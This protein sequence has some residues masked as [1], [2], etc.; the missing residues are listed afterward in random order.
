MTPEH[1]L[2]VED[3]TQFAFN[4]SETLERSEQG[5][6]VSVVHSG[7]KALQE[8]RETR[9]DLVLMDVQLAGE[10]NGVQ[11][12]AKIKAQFDI[13][14]VYLTAYAD[15]ILLQWAKATEPYGYLVKPVPDRELYATV[16]MALYKHSLDKKLKK[17]EERFRALAQNSLDIIT[18]IET[19]GT[20]SY[21]SP[22]LERVLGYSPDEYVGTSFY[23]RIHPED[24]PRV[25]DIFAELL[26]SSG[27]TPTVEFRYLHKD[28]SWR[29]IESSGGNLLDSPAVAGVV[30]SSRDITERKQMEAALEHRSVLLQTAADISHA[31][32]SILNLDELVRQ[33]VELIRERFGLYYVGLFLVEVGSAWVILQAGAGEVGQQI[34]EQGHKL[35]VGGDSMVGWCVANR[36]ACVAQNGIAASSVESGEEI[37]RLDNSSLSETRFELALPL[38][39]RGEAIGA[40]TIQSTRETTFGDEDIEV[41]QAMAN[42]LANAITNARLYQETQDLAAELERR[43]NRRTAQLSKVNLEL[44]A[45][46]AWRRQAEKKLRRHNRN[47]EL[48][49]RVDQ[50]LGSTLDLDRV[51]VTVLEEVHRLLGV[52]SCFIWLRDPE[53]DELVCRQA[54]GPSS[55]LVCGW[56]LPPGE[57]FVGWVVRTGKSLVVPDARIDKRDFKGIDER[58]GLTMCSF[59]TVPLRIQ[60]SVIG[61]L[62][63]ADTSIGC[64][65]KTDLELMEPLAASAA[66]AIENARLYK[67]A[68]GLRVFNENIVR[69]MEEGVLLEDKTGHITFANPKAVEMLGYAPEELVGQ[70]W[71][72][73]VPPEYLAQV[74]EESANRPQGITSRY[75]AALLNREGQQVPVI[76]SARPLFEGERFAGVLVVST[77]ITE[78]KQAEQALR[79]SEKRYHSLFDGMPVGLYRTTPAGQIL[80]AN[81]ALMQMLGIQEQSMLAEINMSDFYVH[82]EEHRQF[83][84]L[85]EREGGVQHW[86][87]QLCRQDGTFLWA[88]LDARTVY[89]DDGSALYFEGSMEDITARKQAQETLQRRNRELSLLNRI[90]HV[91]GSTLELDHVLVNCL[92]EV[93]NLLHVIACSV[94]LID[95]ETDELVCRQATGPQSEVVRGWRLPQGKGLA[96]WAARNRESLIVP[97]ARVDER[98]FKQVDR[99]TGLELRSFLSIPLWAKEKVIGVLQVMDTEVGRFD[100]IDLELLEPL[101]ASAAIAIENAQLYEQIKHRN[102][103]LLALNAI[104]TTI[105]ESPDLDRIL[106]SSL[107]KVLEVMEMDGGGVLLFGKDE[108]DSLELAAHRGFSPESVKEL[109]TYR[110]TDGMIGQ[111]L[112][113][114]QSFMVTNALNNLPSQ[115]GIVRR[116]P[117]HTVACA[118]IKSKNRVLGM[119]G[120]FSRD[121]RQ[122]SSQQVQLLTNIGNQV[123]VAIE[124]VRLVKEASEVELLQELNRLRSE[125]I[126]NVSHELRSPLGLIKVLCTSLLMDDVE[127]DQETQLQFL[128]GIDQETDTLE[129]I[130]NNLLDLSRVESEKLRLDKRPTDL[131]QLTKEII[132]V[133]KMN[134]QSSKHRFVQDFPARPLMATVDARSISQVLRN[135]LNNAVKYSP[136]GGVITVQGRGDDEQCLIG[137]NDQGIGIPPEDWERIF[138][139]FYRVD[140]E[141]TQNIGGVGLGLA[142]CRGIV[143]AHDG[144]IWVEST[145]GSGST[146]YFTLPAGDD[147]ES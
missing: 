85:M 144:R 52:T 28:G 14:V 49:T 108:E 119:L 50:A 132:K 45:E 77:D 131:G 1:I 81:P 70:H 4:L 117:F 79:E 91:L 21:A 112:A 25:A 18:V 75:E 147:S 2:I 97:D 135:L 127:I 59:L 24:Q 12:A 61:V 120:V 39:S 22:S 74:E 78:R 71:S 23:E 103:E 95:P 122:L 40:L 80:D 11:T 100:E 123:G 34:L 107:E 44:E 106:N 9:P 16:K 126:A 51:L 73:F 43:V 54:I 110:V 125:L 104:A 89:A 92:E 26:Q 105:S 145:L 19:D 41:L 57:G 140:N 20:C 60:E 67:E 48:L 93:R 47:L 113:S 7:E 111:A 90:G 84:D 27:I 42:Q 129:A 102:E 32:S 146:F 72:T 109:K 58:T 88:E 31:A 33:A 37:V 36:E 66:V 118:P 3:E 134:T 8:V 94:W 6:R 63:V 98:H 82:L 76:I 139:H 115:L 29:W 137:V 143:E 96:G 114:G 141:S 130:V 5:Y 128:Q 30:G 69:S 101:A 133:I 99:Q 56:R 17:S 13:P 87:A 62:Q 53:T 38:F 65:D 55:E 10:L 35:K 121:P 86:E 68:E 15:D 116:E 124:N 142:V 138:E 83:L 64:F 46:I 136:E